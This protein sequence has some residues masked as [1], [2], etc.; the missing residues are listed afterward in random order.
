MRFEQTTGGI[1]LLAAFLAELV[2]QG[3]AYKI[4]QGD[5]WVEVELTGH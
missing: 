5:V 2:R 1:Q 3:I 4:K